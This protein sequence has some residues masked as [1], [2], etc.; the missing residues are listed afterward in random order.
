MGGCVIRLKRLC[1]NG[2]LFSFTGLC[3][4]QALGSYRAF[5]TDETR[6]VVL[7]FPNRTAVVSPADPGKFAE[8]LAG[9]ASP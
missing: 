2:G 7:R 3:R 9:A 4:N 8:S 1:G 5:V 6:T